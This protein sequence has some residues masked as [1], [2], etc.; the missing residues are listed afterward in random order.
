MTENTA[1]SFL[2]RKRLREQSRELTQHLVLGFGLGLILL[3]LG[4]Y[5]Y[6]ISI[7]A[8]DV[9]W[10]V[11]IGFGAGAILGTLLFPS[12]WR[13]P[14]A[15]LRRFG[16]WVGHALMKVLLAGTYFVFIW[17]V[18]VL[19]RATKGTTPIYEWGSIPPK[20][21]EGWHEKKLPY[22]LPDT[23][24]VDASKGGRTGFLKVL[25]FFVRRGHIIFIPVLILLVSLGIALFFLQ[26]SALAPFIYTLF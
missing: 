17:P 15:L 18:G 25:V 11:S 8:W 21:M 24:G 5:K 16:N 19:L 14:E 7:E 22:D 23:S 20:G 3:F 13:G 12:I 10:K 4:A 9:L 26:T 6:Y 1:G 2:A